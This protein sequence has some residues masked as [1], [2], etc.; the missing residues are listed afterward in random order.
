M[1][2]APQNITVFG[3]V[4][5]SE[6]QVPASELPSSQPSSPAEIRAKGLTWAVDGVQ[7]VA[8]QYVRI[9]HRLF[10]RLNGTLTDVRVIVSAFLQRIDGHVDE[11]NR[12]L[13]GDSTGDGINEAIDLDEGFLLA[14][15][16]TTDTNAAVGG[17]LFCTVAL[18]RGTATFFIAPHILISRYLLFDQFVGWPGHSLQNSIEGPGGLVLDTTAAPPAGD[19][20]EVT[21]PVN[22]RWRLQSGLVT[23]T[24]DGTAAMRIPRIQI[25]VGGNRVFRALAENTVTAS[26]TRIL[27]FSSGASLSPAT[28]ADDI[29]PLPVNLY[30][31]GG[32]IIKTVTS[33]LQTGDQYSA[34]NLL[35]EKWFERSS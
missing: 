23:L 15:G 18:I 10:I 34:A 24:T 4:L 29:I 30:L 32:A 2:D 6:G 27:T 13:T 35:V 33:N 8:A 31:P 7:P 20:M 26:L 11:I 22:E 17:S 25:E 9:G 16:A 21:V 5:T 19:E 14:V 3:N 28:V 12:E 1:A